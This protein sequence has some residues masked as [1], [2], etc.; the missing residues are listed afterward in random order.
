M[1]GYTY[2][3]VMTSIIDLVLSHIVLVPYRPA[4]P[5]CHLELPL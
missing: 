1:L 3:A 5:E 4:K 2:R